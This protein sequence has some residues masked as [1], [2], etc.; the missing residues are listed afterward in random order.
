MP[1]PLLTIIVP[2]RNRASLLEAALRSCQGGAS[3]PLEIIVSDNA[4]SDGTEAVVRKFSEVRYL[5]RDQL[6]P[7][8]E[9]WNLCLSEAQGKYVKVLCDD[10]WLLPGGL[11]REVASLESDEQ[12]VAAASAR[13][14]R[15][16]DGKTLVARKGFT[17]NTTLSGAPIFSQMLVGENILG[18][19][20]AVTFRRDRF[21]GFPSSYQ[22]AADWAA[23][24]LLAELGGVAFLAQPGCAF[25]LHEANLT[26]RYVAEGTDFVEVMALRRECLSRMPGALPLAGRIYYSGIFA[27]RMA[28]RLI[29]LSL[30]GQ[31]GWAFFKRALSEGR[32]PL[33]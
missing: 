21:Q 33:S 12:L 27:Y 11:E 10:D 17:K 29:R 26:D 4:S 8:A 20:S 13:E 15:T 9:H 24:I 14:E 3:F 1:L 16:A 31:S 22:Y 2:T 25:R 6:V 19:P 7:M 5:R 32:A 23:W 30:K 18:P 28:R